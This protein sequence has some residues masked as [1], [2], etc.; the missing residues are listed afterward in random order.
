M[1]PSHLAEPGNR[2][3]VAIGEI[4]PE[5][6]NGPHQKG[7]HKCEEGGNAEYQRVSLLWNEVFLEEQL[8]PIGKGL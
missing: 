5:R 4:A 2:S 6:D 7:G 1:H 8:G 3:V